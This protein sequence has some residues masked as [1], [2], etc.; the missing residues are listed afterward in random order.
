MLKNIKML[1]KSC[2]KFFFNRNRTH[3]EDKTAWVVRIYVKH[4]T[5]FLIFTLKRPEEQLVSMKR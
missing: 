4:R 3:V 1:H 2:Q 5:A